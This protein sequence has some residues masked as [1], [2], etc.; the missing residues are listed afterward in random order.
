[1]MFDL[2]HGL[3]GLLELIRCQRAG[4]AYPSHFKVRAHPV[5]AEQLVL[6]HLRWRLLLANFLHDN[7][8]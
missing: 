3:L 7:H 8:V 1:M 5:L 2:P 6:L 4:I